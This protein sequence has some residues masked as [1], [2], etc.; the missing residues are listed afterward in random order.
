M[1][2]RT[3]GRLLRASPGLSPCLIFPDQKDAFSHL[4][5]SIPHS[6]GG[7]AVTRLHAAV[8]LDQ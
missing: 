5:P 8:S 3:R 4:H 1:A 7:G 6:P 2:I